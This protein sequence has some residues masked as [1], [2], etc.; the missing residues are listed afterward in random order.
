MIQK[1]KIQNFQ[2]HKDSALEFHPGVNVITGASDSGKTAV[3][4]ALRWLIWNRPNGDDFRSDWGGDTVVKLTVDDREIM[5]GKGK[6]NVYSIEQPGGGH[7]MLMA[8]GTKVPEEVQEILNIDD[9]NLQKQFDSP[10]LISANPGEVA[11]YFN[12]IAHLETIDTANTYVKGKI[13][14]LTAKQKAD[15][16]ARK[17]YEEELAGYKYIDKFEI[18]LEELEHQAGELT[19]LRGSRK[20]LESHLKT[21]EENEQAI[22]K[23]ELITALED[24]VDEILT[25]YRERK[26]ENEDMLTLKITLKAIVQKKAEEDELARK[27]ELLPAVEE[28]LRLHEERE[29][30][31]TDQRTLRKALKEVKNT[32]QSQIAWETTFKHKEDLFNENRPDICPLCGE[33]K[34]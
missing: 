12:Q 14:T 4:R 23:K 8:F 34:T 11:R 7:K 17:E 22:A 15:N 24:P 3:I 19:T 1:L 26:E 30:L 18:D 13:Q 16:D 10:F 29:A 6:E 31:Y 20:R 25:L 21:M 33:E 32:K 28:L 9:T 2:S 27:A 5:R